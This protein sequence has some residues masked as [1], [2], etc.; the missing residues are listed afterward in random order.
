MKCD[1]I[2]TFLLPAAVLA[3]GCGQSRP[4]ATND[5]DPPLAGYPTEAQPKLDTI[6]LWVGSEEMTAEMAVTPIEEQTGM[7]FRTNMGEN[8]GMI[9]VMDGGPMQ[10]SFW[11]HNC[12]MPLSAAYIDAGGHIQEIHD[13]QPHNTNAVLSATDNIEFVLETPQ[14]WFK[15]HNINAGTVVA[16][17]KGSLKK[18]FLN[19]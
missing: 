1:W 18:T 4:A 9:F 6:K 12:P 13:L 14:G 16:T 10:A 7:M 19:Q 5:P 8:E 11:M 17:E 15:R 3:A 2:L